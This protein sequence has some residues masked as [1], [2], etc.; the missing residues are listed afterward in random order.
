M[1]LEVSRGGEYWNDGVL[2]CDTIVWQT[3][4]DVL[5]RPSASIFM[6]ELTHLIHWRWWRQIL[7]KQQITFPRIPEHRYISQQAYHTYELQKLNH[8]SLLTP[9]STVLLE[10]LTV[11]HLVVFYGTEKFITM[12]TRARH[13][14]LSWARWIHFMSSNPTSIL[15]L[16]FHLLLDS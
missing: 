6:I 8:M 10:K 9:W 2:G 1:R 4:A 16:S 7:P 5:D 14:A 12:F 15:I 3:G 11:P 13:W